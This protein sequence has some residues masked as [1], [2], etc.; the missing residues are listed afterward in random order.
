MVLHKINK[1]ELSNE[2]LDIIEKVKSLKN[3]MNEQCNQLVESLY[4]DNMNIDTI[5]DIMYYSGMIDVVGRVTVNEFIK[6][7]YKIKINKHG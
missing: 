7:N 6:N 2:E 1:V 5:Q 4:D 3:E